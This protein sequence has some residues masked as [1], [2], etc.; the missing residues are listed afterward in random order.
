MQYQVIESRD[1]E[2]VE[3]LV[4]EALAEGW[5]LQGGVSASLAVDQGR[6]DYYYAQ[7]LIKE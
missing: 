7:A 2:T 6:Y 5:K 1:R 3:E 4:N